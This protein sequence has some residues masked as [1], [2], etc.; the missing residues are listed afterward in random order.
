MNRRSAVGTLALAL[1]L[2]VSACGPW[3]SEPA[4]SEPAPTGATH[5]PGKGLEGDLADVRS[6]HATRPPYETPFDAGVVVP[7]GLTTLSAK[8]CGACHIAIYEEWKVS[9]HAAAWTDRQ[10]RAEIDKSG[11]RWL[12]LNCHTPLLVQQDFWPI[13]LDGDDVERPRLVDNPVFDSALREEGITCAACHVVDGVI[14]GPGV[15]V[16]APHAV[17]ADANFTSE[18]LCVRCHQAAVTYPGKTFACSFGTG[19]EWAASPY[20]AEGKDCRTCHMPRTERPVMAGG[21]VRT[22]GS[23]WWR[24]AGIPKEPGGG[25]PIEANPPGLALDARWDASGVVVIGTNA[26]AGHRLPTGDPERFIL[27]EVHF[28]DAAGAAVGEPFS[29]RIG[30]K[31]EWWPV[32]KKLDDNRLAPRESRTW[33]VPPPAGAVSAVIEASSHRMTDE[34]AAFHHLDDYPRAL[35]THAVTVQAP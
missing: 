24:G 4:P 20:P 5:V 12:C 1:L 16:D 26:N 33:T 19:E 11:N 28:K 27:V 30:Q 18:G 23:H 14:H 13:G 35:V 10:Y 3:R 22:V 34:T 25:P 9:T 2:E 7:K 6:F 8:E 29:E 17:Q 32:A 31:W 21:V 15:A